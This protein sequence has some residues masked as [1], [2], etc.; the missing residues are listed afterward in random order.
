MTVPT[1]DKGPEWLIYRRQHGDT[2][3]PTSRPVALSSLARPVARSPGAELAPYGRF[4]V[5]FF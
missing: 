1:L 3:K 5:H 2:H 4:R